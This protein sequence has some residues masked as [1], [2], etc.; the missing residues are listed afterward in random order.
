MP[1]SAIFLIFEF[2]NFFIFLFFSLFFLL[3]SGLPPI[4]YPLKPYLPNHLIIRQW[5]RT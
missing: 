3:L 2:L 5:I 4:C 1:L